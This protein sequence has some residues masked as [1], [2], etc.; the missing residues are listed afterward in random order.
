[1]TQHQ[2]PQHSRTEPWAFQHLEGRKSRGENNIIKN[3]LPEKSE[4]KRLLSGI[5]VKKNTSLLVRIIQTSI[6]HM[7]SE[8][9]QKQSLTLATQKSLTA[10]KST[11]LVECRAKPFGIDLREM[12]ITG[13]ST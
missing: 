12:G 1:M 2:L 9:W 8:Q 3:R 7:G 5:Q 4:E 11:V 6:Q 13:D 10:F